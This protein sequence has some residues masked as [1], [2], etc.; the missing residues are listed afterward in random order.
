VSG[1]EETS[2]DSTSILPI[3]APSTD[4]GL[5][6][7]AIVTVVVTLAL[8]Q[9]VVTVLALG[10]EAWL[11]VN[12][13]DVLAPGSSSQQFVYDPTAA[14]PSTVHLDYLRYVISM[15]L[16]LGL[17]VVITQVAKG[18]AAAAYTLALYEAAVVGYGALHVV[19]ADV[20]SLMVAILVGG[21]AAVIAVGGLSR[22]ARE[23]YALDPWYDPGARGES[24]TGLAS[25]HSRSV[26]VTSQQLPTLVALARMG[27][28]PQPWMYASQFTTG[29]VAAIGLGLLHGPS[30]V[31]S[32]LRLPPHLP[33]VLGVASVASASV[34]AV[35]TYR[36]PN[37]SELRTPLLLLALAVGCI[38]AW[39]LGGHYAPVGSLTWAELGWWDHPGLMFAGMAASTAGL[40]I[41]WLTYLRVP[42]PDSGDLGDG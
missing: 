28:Q 6:R 32:S 36:A 17:V 8:L 39:F 2:Q 4:D 10:A 41:G 23:W 33:V 24:S 11:L 29:F 31:L 19:A 42:T 14:A 35:L 13:P 7:P 22:E 9:V 5:R 18:R 3:T 26:S 16:V 15:L 30:W 37:R 12:R 27:R 25:T 40:A 34:A 20:S 38:V 21:L 1:S